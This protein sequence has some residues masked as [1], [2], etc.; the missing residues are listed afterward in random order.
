[1]R[2]VPC[3]SVVFACLT[4]IITTMP[5]AAQAQQTSPS[6]AATIATKPAN[7]P[8]CLKLL[9]DMGA[10]MGKQQTAQAKVEAIKPKA[11]QMSEKCAA[12]KYDD[13]FAI[14]KEMAQIAGIKN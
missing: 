8:D 1:M 5:F 3:N 12:E 13:A 10:L 11:Q 9:R 7:K 4:A 14:Y 2:I 6:A